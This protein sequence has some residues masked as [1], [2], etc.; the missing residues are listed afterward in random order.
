LSENITHTAIVD[1]CV[2]LALHSEAVCD[3]F[4]GCLRG[5]REIARLGGVT[6]SGDR[7]TVRLLGELREVWPRRAAGDFVEEKLA[8]VLGWLCHRAADRQMKAIFRAVDGDCRKSP[9]DCSVYHDAF[10]FGE[11]FEG[12]R[13]EPYRP[14]S[15]EPG[16][17]SHPAAKAIPVEEV[18]DLFRAMWQ[19]ML[20]GMHTFIPD[21][22]DI[23][24]WLERV[25]KTR[26]RLYVDIRR[27]A[28]AYAAPD[29]EKVRRFITDVGF[30]DRSDALIR[31][32]RGLQRVVDPEARSRRG[33]EGDLPPLDE[34]ADRAASGSQYAR[35]LRKAYLYVRAA[36]GYFVRSAA[37]E[38]LSVRLEIGRPEY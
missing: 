26:Q 7:F 1:D 11:V 15:L 2:R 12:G 33:G 22:D 34:A 10:L 32:A 21:A 35:A 19:R 20:I 6:R 16:M 25:F 8:F 5:H 9:T 27:Y 24:A 38:D 31:L 28:E 13:A 14:S 18:E 30:Y 23:H 29:P 17:A 3:A 36:S 4:K 37:D